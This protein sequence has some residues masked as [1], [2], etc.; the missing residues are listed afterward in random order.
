MKG[1]FKCLNCGKENKMK[2]PKISRN[3]YCN[4]QCSGEHK[5][6]VRK[7]LWY[8]GELHNINR[9]TIRKYITEDRG[10]KCD[11]CGISDYNGLPITLQ[12]DHIDGN[13]GNHVPENTRLICP[14]CH[15]QQDNWGARNKGSGR[16]SRGMPLH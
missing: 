7:E 13:P 8:A 15:S 14:N 9:E 2:H 12:V 10:Y 11:C 6:R 4:S 1:T 3:K 5:S 16:K